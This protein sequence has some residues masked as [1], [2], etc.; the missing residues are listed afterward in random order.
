[1]SFSSP[2]PF[3]T[4]AH[5]SSYGEFVAGSN[6]SAPMTSQSYRGI[7]AVSTTDPGPLQSSGSFKNLGGVVSP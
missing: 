6:V 1:V 4:S 2:P 3:A 5:F 7:G